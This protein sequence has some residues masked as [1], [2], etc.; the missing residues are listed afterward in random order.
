M[1]KEISQLL[2]H[3][4]KLFQAGDYLGAYDETQKA[5]D[6]SGK[7]VDPALAHLSILSLARSGMTQSAIHR[8]HRMNTENPFPRNTEFLSLEARLYKD[9]LLNAKTKKEKIVL[10]TKAREFYKKAFRKNQEYYPAINVA[11]ISLLMD[12][13]KVSRS[14]SNKVLEICHALSLSGENNFYLYATL[15]E[16][17]LILGNPTEVS[18]NLAKAK[19]FASSD[20]G[21]LSV[22]YNQLSLICQTKKI[23]KSVLKPIQPPTVFCYT[24]HMIHGLGKTPGIDTQD[25]PGLRKEIRHF[26]KESN[27]KIAFGSLASGADILIAEEVLKIKGELNLVFPFSQDEFKSISVSPAGSSWE[28]RFDKVVKKAT[29]VSHVVDDAYTDHDTLFKACTLQAQGLASLRSQT[30]G[31]QSMQLALWN[32]LPSQSNSGTAADIKHWKSLGLPTHI[33]SVP[34]HKSKKLSSRKKSKPKK[35]QLTRQ[36]RTM[37][38]A[39]IRGYSK[40]EE[41]HL[42][43][44]VSIWMN[45]LAKIKKA[46]SKYIY[47]INTWGDAVYLVMKNVTVAAEIGLELAALFNQEELIKNKL[48][49]TLALRVAA[50]MGPIFVGSSPLTGKKDFYGMHVNQTARLEPCTPV[51]SVYATEPF[52]AQVSIECKEKYR[53]E[54]VG[55]QPLAK[56]YGTIR[57][58]H[59]KNK[60]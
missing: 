32:R 59:L 48:P 3:A 31:S 53:C 58:Y 4:K 18:S 40:L 60:S 39:D 42:P 12:D 17:H 56:K 14:W 22:T 52:A 33:I 29:Q 19:S 51:R 43:V 49:E 5:I 50:H 37:I 16:A 15:A 10:G 6:L 1:K 44:F 57:M 34:K 13:L 38:F 25:E 55:N 45:H 11:T 24:G 9:E 47:Y 21:S 7:K 54:Y 36:M 28:K 8:F 23:D 46:H 35:T 26:L 27:A 20:Y 2:T 30:L 41:K